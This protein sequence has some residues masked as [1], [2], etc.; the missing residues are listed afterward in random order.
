MRIALVHDWLLS[1]IGGSERV[2]AQLHSLFS[3]PPIYTLL[4][5]AQAFLD[6]PF[7]KAV[8]HRSFLERMP[9]IKKRWR[10][11]L[12]LFPLAIE[13][14]NLSKY[15]LVFSSSHCVAKGVITTPDQLHICYCHTPMRYAWD[16][17]HDYLKASSW[18]ARLLMHYLRGWDVQSSSRVDHFIANSHFVKRRI[19][20][21]YGKEAHVIYP[22]VDT[23]LFQLKSEK[24][25]FYLAA[26]RL[27]PYKKID[28]IVEAFAQMPQRKLIVIGDGPEM[29]KIR[30]LATPN[31]RIMGF[32]PSHLLR[33]YLQN[34]RALLF[35]AI[36]D[37]GIL[38][39]EAMSAGTPV[40]GL[41]RGGVAETVQDQSTGLFFEEQTVSA[42][43]DVVER[44][45]KINSWNPQLI[46]AHALQFSTERFLREIRTFVETTYHQW[47]NSL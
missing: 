34:A 23:S 8:V 13:Q 24:E 12:P 32:L 37:F 9:L 5:N 30:K 26:S 25:D 22:P 4:W 15:D 33:E 10:Y 41:R 7:S 11:Y 6:T 19:R 45:E 16:L 43:R 14:F 31:I 36:E 21:T 3:S 29:K 44:F 18:P 1:P 35:S 39:V 46:R 47:K 17:S 42:I 2:L 40:L 20:K 28:L 27:V 38:P